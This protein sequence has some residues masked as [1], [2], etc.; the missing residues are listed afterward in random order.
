M[1]SSAFQS[2]HNA[3]NGTFKTSI[4]DVLSI[5]TQFDN[6]GSFS[7]PQDTA[8]IRLLIDTGP[9]QLL[10]L[11][12]GKTFRHTGFFQAQVYVPIQEGEKAALVIADKINDVFRCKVLSSVTYYTPSLTKFGRTSDG[13]FWQIG[14]LCPFKLDEIGVE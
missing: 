7:Q 10:E 3:I 14:V 1:A 4:S 13:A 6:D 5:P 9:S 8:W 12:A 2:L 11:G